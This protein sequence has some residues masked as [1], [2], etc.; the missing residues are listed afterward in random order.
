MQIPPTINA[1]PHTNNSEAKTPSNS[2]T[3]LTNEPAKGATAPRVVLPLTTPPRTSN[4]NTNTA[5]DTM[6]EAED[7]TTTTTAH[8]A[9][10][11]IIVALATAEA[12]EAEEAVEDTVAQPTPTY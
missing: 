12:E 6:A 2:H 5:G 1:P 4:P 9:T 10:H 8:T 11:K 7:T 3:S